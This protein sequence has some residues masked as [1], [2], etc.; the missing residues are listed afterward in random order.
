[1]N[2]WGR[3]HC[4]CQRQ[5]HAARLIVITGGP[6]AGKTATLEMARRTFCEH[7]AI[8]PE[9]ASILFSGGFWRHETMAGKKA[10]Q[11]AIFHVQREQEKLV[12]EEN[13]AALVLC[14]RGTLDS[15]AYWPN[16]P[17]SYF[18]ELNTSLEEEL[19]RYTAVIHLRTPTE[20]NGYNHQNPMRIET[21]AQATEIDSKILRIWE[22]HPRYYVV[23]SHPDFMAKANHV[24]NLIRNELPICCNSIHAKKNSH[25]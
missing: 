3:A 24:L 17:E 8:L 20:N 12:Q 16:S 11:R 15:L 2:E 10:A 25:G 1:M 4:K 13:R 9:A 6:G 7:I 21:A 23:D 18:R 22:Q 14:D 19:A 5:G